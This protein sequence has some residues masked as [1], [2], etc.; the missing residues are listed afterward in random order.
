METSIRCVIASLTSEQLANGGE[1]DEVIPF[2]ISRV[3]KE[4]GQG[5]IRAL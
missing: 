2:D 1:R 4:L 3:S 5:R